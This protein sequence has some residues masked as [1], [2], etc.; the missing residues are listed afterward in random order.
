MDINSLSV[1]GVS[2][3]DLNQS[4]IGGAMGD[5]Q[6]M[7]ESI[8]DGSFMWGVF[9]GIVGMSFSMYGKKSDKDMFLYSGVALMAY[10]Y[11]I[12]GFKETILAGVLL[13]AIPFVVKR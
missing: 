3:N 6:S 1:G 11:F 5:M 10:P 7:T 12:S 13:T 2:I 9:F 8:D 4:G